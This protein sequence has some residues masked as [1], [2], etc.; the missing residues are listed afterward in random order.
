MAG[1]WAVLLLGPSCSCGWRFEFV[2]GSSFWIFLLLCDWSLWEGLPLWSSCSCWLVIVI[3]G[4]G[5]LLDLLAPVFPL[6][7][8][9]SASP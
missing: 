3:C 9:F 1:L 6:L 5:F 2:G 7:H 4:R 8:S